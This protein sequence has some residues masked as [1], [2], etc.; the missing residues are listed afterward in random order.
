MAAAEHKDKCMKRILAVCALVAAALAVGFWGLSTDASKALAPAT[1]AT[2]GE[3]VLT[4]AEADAVESWRRSSYIGVGLSTERVSIVK[5]GVLVKAVLE[6]STAEDAGLKAG[7][8]IVTIDGASLVNWTLENVTRRIQGTIDSKVVLGVKRDGISLDIAVKRDIDE[9]IGVEVELRDPK[10]AYSLDYVYKKAPAA[11]AGLL[12]GD[13][14]I[15][16]DGVSTGGMSHEQVSSALKE[17]R[18]GTTVKVDVLRD[19]SPH[20]FTITRDFVENW[21]AA[22]DLRGQ[23]SGSSGYYHYWMKNLD[24]VDLVKSTDNFMKSI[25]E[26]KGAVIDLRGSRGSDPDIAAALAARFVDTGVVLRYESVKNGQRLEVVYEVKDSKLLKTV[27]VMQNG[28][29]DDTG[30]SDGGLPAGEIPLPANLQRFTG[31]LVVVVDDETAGTAEAL[32]RLLQESGRAT[33]TGF[34]SAG[35]PVLQTVEKR[36]TASGVEETV[37]TSTRRLLARDGGAFVCVTP[38]TRVWSRD[39]LV[40]KAIGQLP[41]EEDH[42]YYNEELPWIMGGVMVVFFGLLML[43]ISVISKR[44]DARAAAKERANSPA[45]KLVAPKP[46]P[47]AAAKAAPKSA[48]K[49]ASLLAYLA[50]I[51]SL[52]FL[53]G[54][55]IFGGNWLSRGMHGAPEGSTAEIVVQLYVDGSEESARQAVIFDEL[56]GEYQG[57]IR[58]EK[59]DVMANPGRV[60]ELNGDQPRFPTVIVR[61]HFKDPTGKVIGYSSNGR[62]YPAP[63]RDLVRSIKWQIEGDQRAGY[64]KVK[65]QRVVPI[66]P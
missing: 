23:M 57:D 4:P 54:I 64:P 48:Q 17:G 50:L 43:A 21:S 36:A 19:R 26:Q 9:R 41:G 56:K 55:V 58:F 49:P 1:Q 5:E 52:L 10:I 39:N 37:A 51:G 30:V 62:G 65:V 7:D 33:V 18:P 6:A 22:I 16:I 60:K 44:A 40:S 31:K 45:P 12:K 28:A 27:Y 35:K 11:L 15:A 32:A 2:A 25:N 20:T 66:K 3:R 38:D 59:I 53:F 47:A 42:Y 14:L 63:K 13:V 46:A 24:Y 61:H 8:V 29:L 34:N